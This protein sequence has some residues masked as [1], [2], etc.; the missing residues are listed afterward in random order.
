[1]CYY[2]FDAYVSTALLSAVEDKSSGLVPLEIIIVNFS[3]T[4]QWH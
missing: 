3:G 2:C 1:M 4:L